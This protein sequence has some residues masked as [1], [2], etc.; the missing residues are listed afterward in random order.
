MLSCVREDIAPIATFVGAAIVAW[1]ALAQAGTARRRH[2]EQT[3]A[4]LERRITESFA[5]AVEQLGS[6]KLEIRLGGIYTLER[7]SHESEREYW[8]IMETLTAYVRERAPWPPREES[9]GS[10]EAAD[11]EKEP[12]LSSEWTQ[13]AKDIQAIL[14]VLGRR[15]E[16]MRAQEGENQHLDLS[17]TDLR[18]TFLV[19]AHLERAY[20][21]GARLE[22]AYLRGAHLEGANFGIA[23]LERAYLGDAHLEGAILD[24][25]H[26]EETNFIGACLEGASFERAYLKGACLDEAHLEG[27]NFKLSD[28]KNA[29]LDGAFLKR[30]HF[31]LAC[32]EGAHLRGA[33]LENA[34]LQGAQLENAHFHG[35]HLEGVK[36]L[37]QEQID[38]AFGDENTILPEGLERPAHWTKR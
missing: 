20:L 32:L 21:I 12:E 35:A 25:A 17:G 2:E 4:D 24:D 16:G 36:Y 37:V 6:E 9:P 10:D 34:I 15:E 26:L 18:S 14:T 11:Q 33:H 22:R 8:P 31:G 29:H 19:G 5:K 28:L 30:A 3:K 23:H 13:P 27:V 7:L 38:Q 1:A